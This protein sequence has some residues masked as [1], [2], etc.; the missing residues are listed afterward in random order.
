MH[1]TAYILYVL[2]FPSSGTQMDLSTDYGVYFFVFA[3]WHHRDRNYG[4]LSMSDCSWVIPILCIR[5][6]RH[7]GQN[8]TTRTVY[9]IQ[10]FIYKN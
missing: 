3:E 8:M 4:R 1:D 6:V 9:I 7:Y 2:H 10:L 5:A